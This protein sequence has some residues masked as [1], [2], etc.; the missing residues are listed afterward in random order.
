MECMILTSGPKFEQ[1]RRLV[2]SCHGEAESDEYPNLD[3]PP[4][5]ITIPPYSF[6]S[7][8]PLGLGRGQLLSQLSNMML[9]NPR[10]EQWC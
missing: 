4:Y 9:G 1:W 3:T 7:K 8:P 5:E 2:C 6:R 10:G